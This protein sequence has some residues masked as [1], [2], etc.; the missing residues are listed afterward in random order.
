MYASQSSPSTRSTQLKA[1]QPLVR[2]VA[3]RLRS[4]LPSHVDMDDLFQSGMIGLDHALDRYEPSGG[5][6]FETYAARRIE[7]AMLDR[8]RQLDE[9]PREAR[10]RHS[11]VRQAVQKLEHLLGRAPR[12]QE[13]A[14]ELDWSLSR[15]HGCMAEVGVG[16]L[17]S[18][19][20][21]AAVRANRATLAATVAP[22]APDRVTSAIDPSQGQ[23]PRNGDPRGSLITVRASYELPVP[24]GFIGLPRFVV[25]ASASRRV[26]WTP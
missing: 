11:L 9:L 10:A 24:L 14:N 22:L 12:A 2:R 5:A 1:H 17:R 13:V 21:D 7:G 16:S 6:S 8:L 25:A 23:P 19:D 26:E 18:G 15:F 4:R 20:D 3:S